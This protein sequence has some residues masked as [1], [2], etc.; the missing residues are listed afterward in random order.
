MNERERQ[1]SE[2]RAYIK[3]D[4]E[5]QPVKWPGTH[6][7]C[8]P[9]CEL[10]HPYVTT[11]QEVIDRAVKYS[12]CVAATTNRPAPSYTPLS[13]L[14]YSCFAQLTCF[15]SCFLLT[16]YNAPKNTHLIW[17]STGPVGNGFRSGTMLHFIRNTFC[18]LRITHNTAETPVQV[19]DTN[20]K[21]RKTS[22]IPSG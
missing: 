15:P 13:W 3:K 11:C 10:C 2:K 7:W 4:R 16:P 22:R 21:L 14:L 17:S 9:Q 8:N 19:Q 20:W 12:F 1:G 18:C 5:G 6:V